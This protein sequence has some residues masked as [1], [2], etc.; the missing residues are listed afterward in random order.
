MKENKKLD[1]LNEALRES[2]QAALKH[3]Q[4]YNQPIVYRDNKNRLI[5]EYSDNRIVII[6]DYNQIN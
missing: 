3:H 5:E 1:F 6:K 4:V 2:D